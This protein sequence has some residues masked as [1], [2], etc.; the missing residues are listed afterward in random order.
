MKNHRQPDEK[1]GHGDDT[2]AKVRWNGDGK[3]VVREEVEHGVSVVNQGDD[4][5]PKGVVQETCGQRG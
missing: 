4:E 3:I 1:E 5:R 2:D